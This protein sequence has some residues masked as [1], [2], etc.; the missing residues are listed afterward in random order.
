MST[1]EASAKYLTENGLSVKVVS[2]ER[3]Y[4]HREDDRTMDV[5][6]TD[7]GYRVSS[8]EYAPGPGTEDF[9]LVIPTLDET[10]L[11]VWCY[12]FAKSIEIAGWQLPI[13]RRPYWRL[14]KLQF[15]LA[16]ASH[17]TAAQLEVIQEER[18]R[19]ALADPSERGMGLA[20][21]DRTQFILAGTHAQS[22]GRLLLRRDME[23]G[24][25]VAD[26]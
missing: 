8:W 7:G 2:S 19:R 9:R 20:F 14:S 17:I 1:L 15:R 13:H 25:V 21:A 6:K 16:H 24:Y 18:R 22:R 10:L 23:E 3:L 4:V 26:A 11:V 12:Y 5:A